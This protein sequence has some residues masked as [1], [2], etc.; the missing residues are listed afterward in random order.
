MAQIQQCILH[1]SQIAPFCN[2]NAHTCAHLRYKLCIMGH[3]S[4]A[5]WDGPLSSGPHAI[6]YI[7]IWCVIFCVTGNR[8][9]LDSHLY[10]NS[11]SWNSCLI[12]PCNRQEIIQS[13]YSGRN[14]NSLV[15]GRCHCIFRSVISKQIKRI[16]FLSTSCVNASRWISKNTFCNKLLSGSVTDWCRQGLYSLRRRRLTGI[17]ISMMNLRR[18]NDRLEFI[19]G[20]PKTV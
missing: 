1:I 8:L 19:M 9:K 6:F 13:N 5:L 14:L 3:L 18:S 2:R 11:Q 17:G 12:I 4:N 7:K 10:T 20:I 16:N 15:P